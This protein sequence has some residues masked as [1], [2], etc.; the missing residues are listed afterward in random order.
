VVVEGYDILGYRVAVGVTPPDARAA[1]R[2]VLRGFGPVALD[3]ALRIPRYDLAPAP[4]GWQV[5]T[6][7]GLVQVDGGFLSSLSILEWH[8]VAAALN[9]RSD[10]FHLHGAALCLPATRAGIVLAGES[11]R[12]KTTLTLALMFRG[13]VPFADDVALLD[14]ATLNLHPLRRAFHVSE[15]TRRLIERV[16]GGP[17]GRDEEGPRDYFSPPQWAADPVPVRWL[18]FVEYKE[19]QTP[20]FVPLSSSEAATA[21]LARTTSLARDTRLALATCA[22]LTERA[23][24]YRFLTGDL[25]ASVAAV[26]RLVNAPPPGRDQHPRE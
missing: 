9:H 21:I 18:L 13:F 10:L 20:Q 5:S 12:G 26:Q 3:P 2:S 25:A 16:A 17:L 8:L 11:G 19:G 7:G 6:D 15:E 1:V 4:T 14:P 23:A 22:R 24:C